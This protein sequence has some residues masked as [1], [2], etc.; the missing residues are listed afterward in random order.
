MTRESESNTKNTSQKNLDQTL[1]INTELGASLSD[2]TKKKI[3]ALLKAKDEA[4]ELKAQ[5]K[6][7]RYLRSPRGH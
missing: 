7:E 6:K 2:D 3:S 4:K 1:K 5:K